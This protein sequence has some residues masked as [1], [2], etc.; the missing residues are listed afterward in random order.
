MIESMTDLPAGVIGFEL[1]GKLGAADYRDIIIPAIERA[2]AGGK[3]RVV[4][5]IDDFDGLSGGALWEDL[6]LAAEHLRSLQRTAIVT[7]LEWMG[8][9][10]SLFGW[11]VHGDVRRFPSADRADA[12]AWVAA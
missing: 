6:K 1:N 9:F 12:I 5:V 7:D 8:H 2:A 3:I 10:I 4:I 11:M